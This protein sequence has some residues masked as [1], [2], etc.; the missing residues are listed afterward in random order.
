MIRATGPGGTGRQGLALPCAQCCPPA[1]PPCC[2]P[3]LRT[4]AALPRCPLRTH[5]ALLSPAAS[6]PFRLRPRC[7][8][9]LPSCCSLSPHRSLY[10]NL[11]S[12]PIPSELVQMTSL[13]DLY[14]Q[15]GRGDTLTMQQAAGR[16][17]R[18]GSR[19]CLPLSSQLNAILPRWSFRVGTVFFPH[20]LRDIGWN[21]LVGRI[22]THI[23]GLTRL[24]YL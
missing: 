7:S 18:A 1:L 6:P 11:L 16:E 19:A 10:G 21:E 24:V 12:G 17:A 9:A 15:A 22:P 20:I 4:H 8:P 2:A 5:A 23:F 13:T 14:A 3:A